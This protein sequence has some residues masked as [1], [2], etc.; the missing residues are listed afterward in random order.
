MQMTGEYHSPYNQL[1]TLYFTVVLI[2]T[3]APTTCEHTHDD[4]QANA[5]AN[6]NASKL[7]EHA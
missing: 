6:A 4:K 2:V 1:L 5:S 3:W 7:N